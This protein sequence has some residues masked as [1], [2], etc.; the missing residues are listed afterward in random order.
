VLDALATINREDGI[1][2][3]CNLHSLE[4]ARAYCGRIVGMAA[5]RLVFDGP[6]SALSAD[7]VRE[8]YGLDEPE[9][10]DAVATNGHLAHV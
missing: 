6:P 5:G 2:V 4:T 3:L 9:A 1:T 10:L 7:R 8:I